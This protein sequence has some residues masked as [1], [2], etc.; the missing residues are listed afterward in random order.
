M[1]AEPRAPFRVRA[2]SAKTVRAP[3]KAVA[4]AATWS[5]R[6]ARCRA[7][8]SSG[9]ATIQRRIRPSQVRADTCFHAPSSEVRVRLPAVRVPVAEVDRP[10]PLLRRVA[11]LRRKAHRGA[12]DVL[13]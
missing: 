9:T 2:E 10:L 11:Y 1:S 8:G 12:D 7:C 5:Q 4:I 6:I 3:P 13:R